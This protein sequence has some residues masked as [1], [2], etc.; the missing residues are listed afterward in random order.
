MGTANILAQ[1]NNA[2]AGGG[3]GNSGLLQA[4]VNNNM[5]QYANQGLKAADSQFM[6]MF[7]QGNQTYQNAMQHQGDYSSGLSDLN[8]GNMGVQNEYNQGQSNQML[9]GIG[10]LMGG[11]SGKDGGMNANWAA[12]GQKVLDFF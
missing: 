8:M 6:N 5:S 3:M 2:Q 7:K 9:G 1:R 12:A 4:A 11:M 10:D